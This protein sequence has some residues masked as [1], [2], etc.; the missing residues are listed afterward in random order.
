MSKQ[1]HG[2]ALESKKGSGKKYRRIRIKRKY[3]QGG[4]F[5]ATKLSDT[6]KREKEHGKGGVL[7]IKLKKAVYANVLTKEGYKKARIKNVIETKD[8]RNFFRLN[9]I[10]KGAI[11]E[12]EL[13]KAIVLNRPGREGAINAKLIE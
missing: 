13:G 8:N 12:T 6:E 1:Y 5:I 3:E 11:I 10:T 4:H 7:K 9:I 2:K